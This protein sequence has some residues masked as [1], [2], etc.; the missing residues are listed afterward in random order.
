M[1]I[2]SVIFK[3]SRLSGKRKISRGSIEAIVPQILHLFPVEL[4]AAPGGIRPF[5][6]NRNETGSSCYL[7]SATTF[8]S[9]CD[10][11]VAFWNLA[12]VYLI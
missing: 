10:C 3:I 2:E 7:R 12:I 4:V 5:L 9:L 1:I 11:S 6:N 8:P